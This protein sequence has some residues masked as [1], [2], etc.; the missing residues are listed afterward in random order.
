[1]AWVEI[2]G[3]TPELLKR[4]GSACLSGKVDSFRPA[5]YPLEA[6]D[7]SLY[8]PLIMITTCE[9]MIELYELFV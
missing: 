1:M 2:D 6:S 8:E 3:G 4:N 5:S 9:N 7:G